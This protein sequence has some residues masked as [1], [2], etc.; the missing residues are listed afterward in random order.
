M[1]GYY[2]NFLIGNHS[3][4]PNL[5]NLSLNFNFITSIP[6]DRWQGLSNLNELSMNRN[7]VANLNAD[8]FRGFPRFKL[9]RMDFNTLMSVDKEAFRSNSLSNISLKCDTDLTRHAIYSF[10]NTPNLQRLVLSYCQYNLSLTIQDMPQLREL[11]ISSTNSHLTPQSRSIFQQTPNLKMLTIG[12]NYL[13]EINGDVLKPLKNLTRLLM[14]D[15]LIRSVDVSTLG[16]TIWGNI[17]ELDLSNSPFD[18]GCNLM[19]FRRWI[20]KNNGTLLNYRSHPNNYNCF[21]P[22][23]N[24]QKALRDIVRPTELECFESQPDWCLLAVGLF[25]VCVAFITLVGSILHRYR[26]HVSYWKYLYTVCIG[27]ILLIL[28]T[29]DT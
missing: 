12:N 14:N 11:D 8:N 6:M 29:V 19:W 4:A 2:P 1:L 22:D 27:N 21:A 18:C 10:H 13:N 3:I 17:Q 25:T 23:Y 9:L 24:Y 28:C 5:R 7:Q 15:A 20:K 16:L 26:W